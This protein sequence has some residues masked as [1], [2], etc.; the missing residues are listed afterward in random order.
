MTKLRLIGAI[1]ALLAAS[2]PAP[3]P[4]AEAAGKICRYYC[5][6]INA[7]CQAAAA[8]LGNEEPCIR[9]YYGC[10]DGCAAPV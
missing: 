10:L 6:T 5:E 1:V 4:A 9:L 8:P 2:P 7:L 3:A